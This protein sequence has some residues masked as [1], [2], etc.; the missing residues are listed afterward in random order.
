M[1]SICFKTLILNQLLIQIQPQ[2]SYY[3]KKTYY[4]ICFSYYKITANGFTFFFLFFL[5]LKHT[6]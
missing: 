4:I 2:L 3:Y 5:D 1:I 6:N